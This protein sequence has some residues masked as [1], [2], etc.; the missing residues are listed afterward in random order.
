MRGESGVPHLVTGGL[1][2]QLLGQPHLKARRDIQ[3]ERLPRRGEI[4]PGVVER[5]VR[6]LRPEAER[7]AIRAASR[8]GDQRRVE[9]AVVVAF[10]VPDVRGR[11]G[12][13]GSGVRRGG[14]G[15]GVGG[16]RVGGL[17]TGG[18]IGVFGVGDRNGVATRPS[19][20]AFRRLDSRNAACNQHDQEETVHGPG[21]YRGARRTQGGSS[22]PRLLLKPR[23]HQPRPDIHLDRAR[24]TVVPVRDGGVGGGE[25]PAAAWRAAVATA[26]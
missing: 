19:R 12:G 11:G 22:G 3:K 17:R 8:P 6:V 4:V 9:A 10:S 14:G 21:G 25:V 5:A 7:V 1:R 20:R 15:F 23:A 18:V 24:R 13:A 16:A 26:P 2:G